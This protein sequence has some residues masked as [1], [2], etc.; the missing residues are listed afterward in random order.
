MPLDE[1]TRRARKVIQKISIYFGILGVSVAVSLV[2]WFY[3]SGNTEHP[4]FFVY[5]FGWP[6]IEICLYLFKDSPF[7]LQSARM[8]NVAYVVFATIQ[9]AIVGLVVG[10]VLIRSGVL[11]STR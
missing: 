10:F 2:A 5:W 9:C 11:R 3:Q 7:N 4:R 6:A 1:C 8:F